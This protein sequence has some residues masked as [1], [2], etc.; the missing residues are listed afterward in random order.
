MNDV[1]AILD[2]LRLNSSILSAYHRK[3]Y[4]TLKSRLKFYRIPII[5]I[6][7][8]N[9]S[10]AVC[11][12]GFINQTFISLINMAL[13]LIV[14]IIGSIEMFYQ[15]SRQMEVELVNSKDCYVLSIDIYK[16]LSLDVSKRN[17]DEKI[18]LSEC[19]TRYTKLIETSYILKKKID[20]KLAEISTTAL[21]KLSPSSEEL[22]DT[23]SN[24]STDV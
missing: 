5:V 13:S 2:K 12:T 10:F 20:D 15:I 22:V 17:V 19:W 1:D 24:G 11:L 18:F 3:R 16:Y 21:M 6:S 14:G 23:S 9:S 4:I 8:L 7:A